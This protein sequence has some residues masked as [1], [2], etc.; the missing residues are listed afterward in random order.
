MKKNQLTEMGLK[1]MTNKK[2]FFRWRAQEPLKNNPGGIGVIFGIIILLLTLKEIMTAWMYTTSVFMSEFKYALEESVM[3]CLVKIDNLLVLDRLSEI[4]YFSVTGDRSFWFERVF[5]LCENKIL[6]NFIWLWEFVS[7]GNVLSINT[8]SES[9]IVGLVVVFLVFLFS[10]LLGLYMIRPIF[11]ILSIFCISSGFLYA[12]SINAGVI[13]AILDLNNY[14]T[15][16][17]SWLVNE[18]FVHRNLYIDSNYYLTNDATKGIEKF[19]DLIVPWLVDNG[20]IEDWG[21]EF[22]I[23]K[24]AEQIKERE[25]HLVMNDLNNDM[26]PNLY[27]K[28]AEDG[29]MLS[30][31]E[32]PIRRVSYWVDMM[33]RVA[34]NREIIMDSWSREE[35]RYENIN[36][37]NNPA[38]V[39]NIW[40]NNKTT[41]VHN[42]TGF[43]ANID[44]LSGINN[45]P[46][47]KRIT[48]F[49]GEDLL[50]F[51]LPQ[52]NNIVGDSVAK[53]GNIRDRKQIV[54]RGSVNTVSNS[55]ENENIL[56]RPDFNKNTNYIFEKT[57]QNERT[58]EYGSKEH[59]K[60]Y[61]KSRFNNYWPT[62]FETIS[63][64]TQNK[65]VEIF[66]TD[67]LNE[68]L[69]Y[70]SKLNTKKT[71][72][73][74]LLNT[75]NDL[76]LNNIATAWQKKNNTK[77]F[78]Q[79]REFAYEYSFWE[80]KELVTFD[81]D[82]DLLIEL[83]QEL[84]NS[85]RLGLGNYTYKSSDTLPW[86]LNSTKNFKDWHTNVRTAVTNNYVSKWTEIQYAE[87]FSELTRALSNIGQ[88]DSTDLGKIGLE[89]TKSWKSNEFSTDEFYRHFTKITKNISETN[90]KKYSNGENLKLIAAS[91]AGLQLNSLNTVESEEFEYDIEIFDL[92]SST[93]LQLGTLCDEGGIYAN[94]NLDYIFS[95]KQT[96]DDSILKF[97][98]NILLKMWEFF[99]IF[100]LFPENINNN[101]KIRQHELTILQT[102]EV[103]VRLKLLETSH[104]L[105]QKIADSDNIINKE[106]GTFSINNRL[107]GYHV[108][109][110]RVE[111][112][113]S[114]LEFQRSLSLLQLKKTI[115]KNNLTFLSELVK[116]ITPITRLGFR[117]FIIY[118]YKVRVEGL[119]YFEVIYKRLSLKCISTT[120]ATEF[121]TSLVELKLSI[122]RTITIPFKI[123]WTDAIDKIKW[124]FPLVVFP[125]NNALFVKKYVALFKEYNPEWRGAYSL[126]Q[127]NEIFH[128]GTPIIDETLMYNSFL[129][130]KLLFEITRGDK[131]F[132]NSIYYMLDNLTNYFFWENRQTLK[133]MLEDTTWTGM[134]DININEDIFEVS[135]AELN[136]TNLV[137]GAE[138]INYKNM[139][140]KNLD[141][142]LYLSKN[143][144]VDLDVIDNLSKYYSY[145]VNQI[146]LVGIFGAFIETILWLID[147][148]F[149][150]TL[151]MLYWRI[152]K[153]TNTLQ[154]IVYERGPS[155]GFNKLESGITRLINRRKLF[156]L[157]NQILPTNIQSNYKLE[158][159]YA[160]L[161]F[162]IV[163]KWVFSKISNRVALERYSTSAQAVQAFADN[164]KATSIFKNIFNNLFYNKDCHYL[165][166]ASMHR[167]DGLSFAY[168]IVLAGSDGPDWFTVQ[169]N[170]TSGFKLHVTSYY[171]KINELQNRTTFWTMRSTIGLDQREFSKNYEEPNNLINLPSIFKYYT[172][173]KQNKVPATKIGKI[174]ELYRPQIES[175]WSLNMPFWE[176]IFISNGHTDLTN[177]KIWVSQDKYFFNFRVG[178]KDI[179]NNP[180]VGFL[181]NFS[182][183]N[184][185]NRVLEDQLSK[186]LGKFSGKNKLIA[187]I[188]PFLEIF[189]VDIKNKVNNSN[190]IGWYYLLKS[191]IIN[192][193]GTSSSHFWKKDFKVISTGSTLGNPHAKL[194][195]N[196]EKIDYKVLSWDTNMHKGLS[197]SLGDLNLLDYFLSKKENS[198]HYLN[199]YGISSAKISANSDNFVR[200][201]LTD[202]MEANKKNKINQIVEKN[203]VKTTNLIDIGAKNIESENL[204]FTNTTHTLKERS[205][206]RNRVNNYLRLENIVTPNFKNWLS[207]LWRKFEK[208]LIVDSSELIWFPDTK[209]LKKINISSLILETIRY[210]GSYKSSVINDA[211]KNKIKKFGVSDF[212]NSRISVSSEDI[213]HNFSISKISETE[214]YA[215]IDKGFNTNDAITFTQVESTGWLL[216]KLKRLKLKIC[217]KLC[218]IFKKI[219]L[220]I[221]FEKSWISWK[222]PEFWSKKKIPTLLKQNL[223]PEQEYDQEYSE[224][225]ERVLAIAITKWG[226]LKKIGIDLF[227]VLF[228]EYLENIS[229]VRDLTIDPEQDFDQEYLESCT[230]LLEVIAAECYRLGSLCAAIGVILFFEYLDNIDEIP[231]IYLDCEQWF[232]E[233]YFKS[234]KELWEIST[235]NIEII[236]KLSTNF[237]VLL[238]YDY[239]DNSGVVPNRVEEIFDLPPEL[240]NHEWF[241]L[242]LS[243]HI[244]KISQLELGRE[245]LNLTNL[246]RDV[247]RA[248]NY[249]RKNIPIWVFNFNTKSELLLLLHIRKIKFKIEMSVLDNCTIKRIKN[250]DFNIVRRLIWYYE[251]VDL[252]PIVNH[253]NELPIWHRLNTS[254][255]DLRNDKKVNEWAYETYLTKKFLIWDK[256][257]AEIFRLLNLIDTLLG[258]A[259][260]LAANINIFLSLFFT[261]YVKNYLELIPSQNTISIKVF[262]TLLETYRL[263]LIF[264]KK[265]L[266]FF[267]DIF[268]IVELILI[269]EIYVELFLLANR[270]WFP[271]KIIKIN[272]IENQLSFAE[273]I[274]PGVILKLSKGWVYAETLLLS[275]LDGIQ[276][277]VST[278]NLKPIKPNYIFDIDHT[279]ITYSERPK[280]WEE[281]V[282]EVVEGE[283]LGVGD[284]LVDWDDYELK[285]EDNFAQIFLKNL[286]SKNNYQEEYNYLIQSIYEFGYS[287]IDSNLKYLL[288]Y[289]GGI[290]LFYNKIWSGLET[291]FESILQL[292]WLNICLFFDFIHEFATEVDYEPVKNPIL[293]LYEEGL[294]LVDEYFWKEEGISEDLSLR[295]IFSDVQIGEDPGNEFT[296]INNLLEIPEDFEK[297][298]HFDTANILH[299]LTGLDS[300]ELGELSP[301]FDISIPI[302]SLWLVGVFYYNPTTGGTIFLDFEGLYS[303]L[304][305]LYLDRRLLTLSGIYELFE[306]KLESSYTDRFLFFR[307]K[308]YYAVEDLIQLLD[309]L[310]IDPLDFIDLCSYYLVFL[311]T[312]FGVVTPLF[313]F[314]FLVYFAKVNILFEK[315]FRKFGYNDL[316]IIKILSGIYNFILFRFVYLFVSNAFLFIRMT[317]ATIMVLTG[318]LILTEGLHLFSVLRVFD[319]DQE[320][321]KYLGGLYFL[322]ERDPFVEKHT[323]SDEVWDEFKY[324]SKIDDDWSRTHFERE[325][326]EIL[327]GNSRERGTLIDVT[328]FGKNFEF[329]NNFE[330]DE[331]D[332]GTSQDLNRL[333]D[334]IHNRVVDEASFNLKFIEDSELEREFF[335]EFE[336]L[337][338]DVEGSVNWLNRSRSQIKHINSSYFGEEYYENILNIQDRSEDT[339]EVLDGK[340]YDILLYNSMDPKWLYD[341]SLILSQRELKP[342]VFNH[343]LKQ[344][345]VST[346]VNSPELSKFKG[347]VLSTNRLKNLISRNKGSI[348]YNP[349][350]DL[351][352][353]DPITDMGSEVSRQVFTSYGT[354]ANTVDTWA[355]AYGEPITQMIKYSD[356]PATIDTIAFNFVVNDDDTTLDFYKNE[357]LLLENNFDII[358]RLRLP[359]FGNKPIH[360][361]T[362]KDREAWMVLDD[363]ENYTQDEGN[364]LLEKLDKNDLSMR[365]LPDNDYDEE[366]GSEYYFDWL[367]WDLNNRGGWIELFKNQF[368]KKNELSLKNTRRRDLEEIKI[369]GIDR[370]GLFKENIW[371]ENKN[372]D[373]E[374]KILNTL[375]KY[376]SMNANAFYTNNEF[377]TKAYTFSQ[378][379]DNSQLQEFEDEDLEMELGFEYQ[380]GRGDKGEESNYELNPSDELEEEHEELWGIFENYYDSGLRSKWNQEKVKFKDYKLHYK[381]KHYGLLYKFLDHP[382]NIDKEAVMRERV[383]HNN[384]KQAEWESAIPEGGRFWDENQQELVSHIMERNAKIIDDFRKD[385]LNY[386]QKMDNMDEVISKTRRMR[387]F[388]A[389]LSKLTYLE[390]ARRNNIFLNKE[391]ERTRK[392][393][394]EIVEKD[395]E[396]HIDFNFI[397]FSELWEANKEGRW[398]FSIRDGIERLGY[399]EAFIKAIYKKKKIPEMLPGILE[400]L[401]SEERR[402]EYLL[403][404]REDELRELLISDIPT[405][406]YGEL[407]EDLVFREEKELEKKK[408][409]Y[410]WYY[411]QMEAGLRKKR[412]MVEGLGGER[413]NAYSL[414][415]NG[416][417]L[418]LVP[419]HF[420]NKQLISEF[421]RRKLN[422]KV[423]QIK[424]S[425][426][427]NLKNKKPRYSSL[428]VES[429][430]T[431][432]K[433]FL[434]ILSSNK[435]WDINWDNFGIGLKLRRLRN[436]YE[437]VKV[438][439]IEIKEGPGPNH[440]SPMGI[441]LRV[442][443]L[444]E[445]RNRALEHMDLM[446]TKKKKELR[447]RVSKITKHSIPNNLVG[448]DMRRN[449]SPPIKGDLFYKPIPGKSK[450][451][452]IGTNVEGNFEQ[453]DD[454]LSAKLSEYIQRFNQDSRG[455]VLSEHENDADALSET[456]YNT[457]LEDNWRF[458]NKLLLNFNSILDQEYENRIPRVLGTLQ[459]A[460][461]LG[462]GKK[463]I[464]KLKKQKLREFKKNFSWDELDPT[465]EEED[466]EEGDLEGHMFDP[467]AHISSTDTS[468]NPLIGNPDQ[469]NMG[470]VLKKNMLFGS[471]ENNL[472]Y[473]AKDIFHMIKNMED[474]SVESLA[475]TWRWGSNVRDRWDNLILSNTPTP[476]DP[477]GGKWKSDMDDSALGSVDPLEVSLLEDNI[478]EN[479][480]GFD[481]NSDYLQLPVETSIRVY[482]GL[483][484]YFKNRP[485]KSTI[486]LSK[487]WALDIN[488]QYEWGSTQLW[489]LDDRLQSFGN[490][491]S[492]KKYKLH[493]KNK[494]KIILEKVASEDLHFKDTKKLGSKNKLKINSKK[495]DHLEYN[496]TTG[497]ENV[498]GLILPPPNPKTLNREVVRDVSFINKKVNPEKIINFITKDKHAKKSAL[499]ENRYT[500]TGKLE[501][502]FNYGEYEHPDL[503]A[504]DPF[505]VQDPYVLSDWGSDVK[506]DAG[507]SKFNFLQRSIKQKTVEREYF[508]KNMPGNTH[509][510]N[511]NDSADYL[512]AL[513][514]KKKRLKLGRILGGIKSSNLT[515]L[516]NPRTFNTGWDSK[517]EAPGVNYGISF[518]N[519]GNFGFDKEEEAFSSSEFDDIWVSTKL[520][521]L[522]GRTIEED[523]LYD[524]YDTMLDSDT[525]DFAE[526]SKF[527]NKKTGRK[528]LKY[529]KNLK[530]NLEIRSVTGGIMDLDSIKFSDS[531]SLYKKAGYL[532]S[533]LKLKPGH[534]INRASGDLQNFLETN[535][536]EVGGDF[537]RQLRKGKDLAVL[538]RGL[539][540]TRHT[541]PNI[542]D[543]G[544]RVRERLKVNIASENLSKVLQEIYLLD[545]AL[546]DET[547]EDDYLVDDD[548]DFD[549]IDPDD[550]DFGDLDPDDKD[551]FDSETDMLNSGDISTKQQIFSNMEEAATGE[552]TDLWTI[553]DFDAN[554]EEFNPN[555]DYSDILDIDLETAEALNFEIS[556]NLPANTLNVSGLSTGLGLGG[557]NIK[558]NTKPLYVGNLNAVN[559]DTGYGTLLEK[560]KGSLELYSL[561]NSELLGLRGNMAFSLAD[562]SYGLSGTK[563][564][565]IISGVFDVNSNTDSSFETKDD[566]EVEDEM[567]SNLGLNS[568][569][570]EDL[571]IISNYDDE[572]DDDDDGVDDDAEGGDLGF[573]EELPD[574]YPEMLE[575]N[576]ELQLTSIFQNYGEIGIDTPDLKQITA[577]GINSTNLTVD[578]EDLVDSDSE[579][580]FREYFETYTNNDSYFRVKK[581]KQNT[582]MKSRGVVNL[583]S[584]LDFYDMGTVKKKINKQNI[585]E[586]SL[587]DS[588]LGLPTNYKLWG[589]LKLQK[590]DLEEQFI[591]GNSVVNY[592][593]EPLKFIKNKQWNTP[594]IVQ[595]DSLEFEN[596]VSLAGVNTWYDAHWDNR[597]SVESG[598]EHE[599]TETGELST[600]SDMLE[601]QEGILE[602]SKKKPGFFNLY[603]F[604]KINLLTDTTERVENRLGNLRFKSYSHD[605][606]I[607]ILDESSGG[608]KSMATED[609]AFEKKY[610]LVRDAATDVLV[611]STLNDEGLKINDIDGFFY[612]SEDDDF[613]EYDLTYLKKI[614]LPVSRGFR[615]KKKKL[616][617]HESDYLLDWDLGRK[618]NT[619]NQNILESGD[620]RPPRRK[621]RRL[622]KKLNRLLVNSGIRIRARHKRRTRDGI[623]YFNYYDSL[624]PSPFIRSLSVDSNLFSKINS[625]R[626]FGA[627][628][629]DDYLYRP[630]IENLLSN[631][632]FDDT[633]VD[634]L[635]E[636]DEFIEE[637]EDEDDVDDDDGL[638]DL[639]DDGT[640]EQ[641]DDEYDEDEDEESDPDFEES[642]DN[643]SF[644]EDSGILLGLSK[645]KEKYLIDN[646]KRST[647]GGFTVLDEDSDEDEDYLP[648]ESFVDETDNSTKAGV[649]LWHAVGNLDQD[650]GGKHLYFWE[651]EEKR[652]HGAILPIEKTKNGRIFEIQQILENNLDEDLS[653]FGLVSET[654]LNAL[655]TVGEDDL[656]LGGGGEFDDEFEDDDDDDEDDYDDDDD[657]LDGI[658]LD[659]DD[660]TLD[661]SDD[662]D[663]LE[664]DLVTRDEWLLEI[665]ED[666]IESSKRAN[667]K[668]VKLT[669]DQ[670][671][672]LEDQLINSHYADLRERGRLSEMSENINIALESAISSGNIYE[673]FGDLGTPFDWKNKIYKIGDTDSIVL[674]RDEMEDTYFGNLYSGDDYDEDDED[675]D[676]EGAEDDDDDLNDY[677]ED[678]ITTEAFEELNDLMVNTWGIISPIEHILERTST[679]L[680][681][682]L[683]TTQL[684]LDALD[685]R[686]DSVGLPDFM[687]LNGVDVKSKTHLGG[688]LANRNNSFNKKQFNVEDIKNISKRNLQNRFIDVKL[689]EWG[690]EE[691]GH[692]DILEDF[693]DFESDSDAVDI[694]WE[695]GLSIDEFLDTNLLGKLQN[696]DRA[697]TEGLL[698]ELSDYF[699]NKI[700]EESLLD[701]GGIS[702]ISTNL[703]HLRSKNINTEGSLK[704][705]GL[706][707]SVEFLNINKIPKKLNLGDSKLRVLEQVSSVERNKHQQFKSVLKH[708]AGD[709]ILP[710][711]IFNIDT[712]SVKGG[713]SVGT[714]IR[715][716]YSKDIATKSRVRW[717]KL[718][719][720]YLNRLDL[721]ENYS[722]KL[723][724]SI[725]GTTGLKN[726]KQNLNTAEIKKPIHIDYF[727]DSINLT[728]DETSNNGPLF[729]ANSQNH[730]YFKKKN[731]TLGFDIKNKTVKKWVGLEGIWN[732]AR[733]D[734]NISNSLL[735]LKKNKILQQKLPE[736]SLFLTTGGG[737]SDESEI[738]LNP[739][740]FNRSVP[741]S[742]VEFG[743]IQV[744]GTSDILQEGVIELSDIFSDLEEI[745]DEDEGDSLGFE[746]SDDDFLEEMEEGGDL[747]E[748]EEFGYSRLRNNMI[749]LMGS[750]K[751]EAMIPT[752]V[753]SAFLAKIPNIDLTTK[754]SEEYK[755]PLKYP[756]EK[757]KILGGYAG[758]KTMLE[759]EEKNKIKKT[760]FSFRKLNTPNTHRKS[761]I[762]DQFSVHHKSLTRPGIANKSMW[763]RYNIEPFNGFSDKNT[764]LT[765]SLEYG[766]GSNVYKN[767]A[768]ARRLDELQIRTFGP[769]IR[770]D[771]TIWGYGKLDKAM[772]QN[773]NTEEDYG[774]LSGLGYPEI[775]E[776]NV[777]DET[778]WVEMAY[779]GGI[780]SSN[781]TDF[782]WTVDKLVGEDSDDRESEENQRMDRLLFGHIDDGED[783]YGANSLYKVVHIL[784]QAL[785]LSDYKSMYSLPAGY[786]RFFSTNNQY[787]TDLLKGGLKLATEEP[788]T[789]ILDQEENPDLKKLISEKIYKDSA[790][791]DVGPLGFEEGETLYDNRLLNR[792]W[793]PEKIIWDFGLRST[794]KVGSDPATLELLADYRRSF[795]HEAENFGNNPEREAFRS[796]TWADNPIFNAIDDLIEGIGIEEDIPY[797]PAH[798]EK[799]WHY[800]EYE[801]RP[802]S[803]KL[804]ER[805]LENQ[806]M[807]DRYEFEEEDM[808][809][810]G[811]DS[812]PTEIGGTELGNF[813]L[814]GLNDLIAGNRVWSKLSYLGGLEHSE[815]PGVSLAIADN[816][817]YDGLKTDFHNFI[818]EK[819]PADPLQGL[820]QTILPQTVEGLFGSIDTYDSKIPGFSDNIT[821]YEN[822]K[823]E[824]EEYIP[825]VES[826]RIDKKFQM[827]EQYRPKDE[828]SL[829]PTTGV[830][831][832]FEPE[833]VVDGE[834]WLGN[835]SSNKAIVSFENLPLSYIDP[836]SQVFTQPRGV[837]A[838][839][840]G[841]DLSIWG[842]EDS[843][844]YSL[845]DFTGN[846]IIRGRDNQNSGFPM[847][848]AWNMASVPALDSYI[849]A[850]EWYFDD[851][852]LT[853]SIFNSEDFIVFTNTA[854]TQRDLWW[855][856]FESGGLSPTAKRELGL[857]LVQDKT[858]KYRDFLLSYDYKLF[859]KSWMN[860]QNNEVPLKSYSFYNDSEINS[861]FAHRDDIDG[862][863][864]G[865][866]SNYENQQYGDF[867]YGLFLTSNTNFEDSL[868][869]YSVRIRDYLYYILNIGILYISNVYLVLYDI[870][871]T[872]FENSINVLF[873]KFE[874]FI[875]F[876]EYYLVSNSTLYQ[877]LYV[878]YPIL[879][880]LQF[881][882]NLL[883]YTYTKLQI[884][885]NLAVG[886]TDNSLVGGSVFTEF[887]DLILKLLNLQ[888]LEGYTNLSFSRFILTIVSAML[889]YILILFVLILF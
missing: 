358:K 770:L 425:Y 507:I 476:R 180:F 725:L 103:P 9:N 484:R 378:L 168:G 783:S 371:K 740:T 646:L 179:P 475:E 753:L 746:E 579:Q 30:M 601:V 784:G 349:I 275:G 835:T 487:P 130:T 635:D 829:A 75:D 317:F 675:E 321:T 224:S 542:L 747:F 209:K 732:S 96:V 292:L 106:V 704:V 604:N 320:N 463:L 506:Y 562:S 98:N 364:T 117:E 41:N 569:F 450:N 639:S 473:Q 851:K 318:L 176:D 510:V 418:R 614:A 617:M 191:K 119:T 228:F 754:L 593:Q 479:I 370:P 287:N 334:Q 679:D 814:L 271:S 651:F 687:Y 411:P 352:D 793:F 660:D 419:E 755:S 684:N 93:Q 47:K 384:E 389:K 45:P 543:T 247:F 836:I 132:I 85:N 435:G 437:G 701:S 739:P 261:Y 78:E 145:Y 204:L 526:Y 1:K 462:E 663:E 233:E 149:V 839:K 467:G 171:K 32:K 717:K 312:Y 707:E 602:L 49:E 731:T 20:E 226:I 620:R 698:I 310:I 603:N 465:E 803:D 237:G 73:L 822:Y 344:L 29:S 314:L 672:N 599:Y 554:Q 353:E 325:T 742:I 346:D 789:D 299:D 719:K 751:S 570:G 623:K 207:S 745:L 250:I 519:Y 366:E 795:A 773:L 869:F 76:Y 509:A 515:E 216:K 498:G 52:K 5:L 735:G 154:L 331:E 827:I 66:E 249:K 648:A 838:I 439:D 97:L 89:I 582:G 11:K 752:E 695:S 259:L 90:K 622:R 705:V 629:L 538:E 210:E 12:V 345:Y 170:L 850:D 565:E 670:S 281:R 183:V 474:E 303:F 530:Q 825:E 235:A 662:L 568:D 368:F 351:W 379:M 654:W 255:V 718:K 763:S 81:E 60:K 208:A 686:L 885:Q 722:T 227:I 694:D 736:D 409:R 541:D 309:I 6:S 845:G 295:A 21:P 503:V 708:T 307:L 434:P 68:Y 573:S 536:L 676:D 452:G 417:M 659:D 181:N 285:L 580:T 712:N 884:L 758:P 412:K 23:Q 581:N 756:L 420:T 834:G 796:L 330:L 807:Q 386:P 270:D 609:L 652:D 319:N 488:P 767:N 236:L 134:W 489:D 178:N 315:N 276:K 230:M 260:Y 56:R 383:R 338:P 296:T 613:N 828:L 874:I 18:T 537:S 83:N 461:D 625:L 889:V 826:Q 504:G 490:L 365:F 203:K 493:G 361:L 92:D 499:S 113:L 880:I 42:P 262:E 189:S 823:Y 274:I 448:E 762:V 333:L 585:F 567:S 152:Q 146:F 677:E 855:R 27:L 160:N 157:Q 104:N 456:I 407:E 288:I 232:D 528:K 125:K 337:G 335:R 133:F 862:S 88:L 398:K 24:Q 832:T 156:G 847:S 546:I 595:P 173:V 876:I 666:L 243:T 643:G 779:G 286:N 799:M 469:A 215:L 634:E 165:W 612:D 246:D 162:G 875:F 362:G 865:I 555:F 636:F 263:Y 395:T 785:N 53:V 798:S 197:T 853:D 433:N 111:F 323:P 457:V 440:E 155:K 441:K 481:M 645:N 545:N 234:F 699:L 772:D 256:I 86:V 388:L 138:F 513:K 514:K 397:K 427:S 852:Y 661:E 100:F 387:D 692:E 324:D 252:T 64:Q 877:N 478:V 436:D 843:P 359:G 44:K 278:V 632:S 560:P 787:I 883:Y 380:Y 494:K 879:K 517:I 544:V 139:S 211:K 182:A 743:K 185:D 596:G 664:D 715:K 495:I 336:S 590:I 14:S 406:A 272:D 33:T 212:V 821:M 251:T 689:Q 393:L 861:W 394:L 43:V 727:I 424:E 766:L 768:V 644:I 830:H 535:I 866:A 48:F 99:G 587:K 864:A 610:G 240:V 308:F 58:G 470:Y 280:F 222:I 372:I 374:Y 483:S 857:N 887:L 413:Q 776:Q 480:G 447:D 477:D 638:W 801:S 16:Y 630:K 583:K 311:T 305:V 267:M 520:N 283:I 101:L 802:N 426:A 794:T 696:A 607:S 293:D 611:A 54:F 451:T 28:H 279:K 414:E 135:I 571:E 22:S 774:L 575:D 109:S 10:A 369:D 80:D 637:I 3:V 196:R 91:S 25:R 377:E 578:G 656:E 486:T 824:D 239:L 627:N 860:P 615:H 302:K 199:N 36:F 123:F 700:E 846:R 840:I 765:R 195:I 702:E 161:G 854:T 339:S 674:D 350:L 816:E 94:D 626:V 769:E 697:D 217:E 737:F 548:E 561:G 218:W 577:I 400:I 306:F 608:I 102:L 650:K 594:S 163:D 159:L 238:F 405:N 657:D 871:L 540:T 396:R 201:I 2:K 491:F 558:L 356:N 619:V 429:E 858:D 505:A 264:L 529:K 392:A 137:L 245:F 606:E 322:L 642:P 621:F 750:R 265:I 886:I 691:T 39:R 231:E 741:I 391:E 454:P 291:L 442:R 348:N 726:N 464:K 136:R 313:I 818:S 878:Y 790:G 791:T 868:E 416:F 188:S 551:L 17:I 430:M 658:L 51:V 186:L 539:S 87:M 326:T 641:E 95:D 511:N 128:K 655:D 432:E 71:K 492:D 120:R 778:D 360:T 34:R 733:I 572:D 343:T 671:T 703:L 62:K 678:S 277:L 624:I 342:E 142:L 37:E 706:P 591:S 148:T 713:D 817:L 466:I 26:T 116:K 557:L 213:V 867:T 284:E 730:K 525:K 786:N 82:E 40:K 693:E 566:R 458:S 711:N 449:P 616:K 444:G 297:W 108:I 685:N 298:L 550:D 600:E 808:N 200:P 282:L 205:L 738:V 797:S 258:Y 760:N 38:L 728:A 300:P 716:A 422:K 780:F 46:N 72:N 69:P 761:H 710:K 734:A 709:F 844:Y 640:F 804:E 502:M 332:T 390:N 501:N 169:N 729:Q 592:T 574:D 714:V 516:T 688:K 84:V 74:K 357:K 151:I 110:T 759:L 241:E 647:E 809:D 198:A 870:G 415:A 576:R 50:D 129:Q 61:A 586:F 764:L 421:L 872:I 553:D 354:L 518:E 294:D 556:E 500:L 403:A 873:F 811:P 497:D 668:A 19:S 55:T 723:K 628:R 888:I 598:S 107:V 290:A 842:G 77:T 800:F 618:V 588:D 214:I 881:I 812:D 13:L 401:N 468:V 404:R 221:L 472:D 229:S 192:I 7:F 690:L 268:H 863:N 859:G 266:W 820:N 31:L 382:P 115:I 347:E 112:V 549:D 328:G 184:L 59:L 443:V 682:K 482:N 375:N 673:P 428:N 512:W 721:L 355:D 153:I 749:K 534:Y 680:E 190:Y 219:E 522:L 225:F 273:T 552:N 720:I 649:N 341:E 882:F 459:D 340:R 848:S 597:L 533:N 631:S 67:K 363:S 175:Y 242:I 806:S 150:D 193:A 460:Q 122:K 584:N 79:S 667:T 141:E 167:W 164:T 140:E 508:L 118:V 837:H 367:F 771:S 788:W 532:A 329:P 57:L 35:F 423:E 849:Y 813:N 399:Q 127:N 114:L 70:L 4:Y 446:K 453:L 833:W 177:C 431:L 147:V 589:D 665:Y 402:K 527:V 187:I 681:R 289:E 166:N 223:L 202:F 174:K 158:S 253:I 856:A 244:F 633:E 485:E 408:I 438:R 121:C 8:E 653:T 15:E 724:D 194:S 683:G 819:L 524:L 254:L 547:R 605:S 445:L 65:N 124:N 144:K 316:L 376:R 810:F 373:T 172:G 669:A 781:F 385:P 126:F 327:G 63:A 777:Y 248:S 523:S 521:E 496:P 815:I 805:A 381:K 257:I 831:Q 455:G 143:Q 531:L 220:Y 757:K 269:V 410:D 841:D 564:Q 304:K 206:V 748:E 105:N 744:G 559:I 301:S 471:L 775:V 792:G 131:T 563:K 782:I